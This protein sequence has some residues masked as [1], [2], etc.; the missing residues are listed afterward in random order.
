MISR[1]YCLVCIVLLSARFSAQTNAPQGTP[2]PAAAPIE[3]VTLEVVKSVPA[4][5]PLEAITKK[6]QG[7]VPVSV[8]ISPAGDVES[9]EADN[10]DPL[11]QAPALAAAKQW[12]FKAHKGDV[13]TPTKCYANVSFEFQLPGELTSS[14]SPSLVH[15][16]LMQG[17]EFPAS[18]RVSETV[19]QGMRTKRVDPVHPLGAE[20]AGMVVLETTVGADGKVKDVSP[21]SGQNELVRAAEDAVRQWEFKPYLLAGE[22][23]AVITRSTV[24]FASEQPK[25]ASDSDVLKQILS[26]PVPSVR[27]AAPERIRLNQGVT[28][29]LLIHK[30]Q[31]SYPEEA[32][33]ALIEGDVILAVIID[34]NGVVR[35]LRVIDTA[36]PL[37]NEAAL[38]AVKGWHYRPFLVNGKPVEVDTTIRIDFQIR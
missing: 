32:K 21:L 1:L 26:A 10:G 29:K 17:G 38:Q 13:S 22:P 16:M 36:S 20:N 11:L 34:K 28:Q 2:S 15:G 31:P 3:H 19:M 23:V 35:D 25:A 33:R 18:L 30:V 27:V 37:L 6:I 9:A 14:R 7:S 5:Y 4:E 8:V 12:K 24:N